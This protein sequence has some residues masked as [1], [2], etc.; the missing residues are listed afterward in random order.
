YVTSSERLV[1]ECD[2]RSDRCTITVTRFLGPM[3]DPTLGGTLAFAASSLENAQYT[4]PPRAHQRWPLLPPGGA[5]DLRTS[6][7]SYAFSRYPL[8]V[9]GNTRSEAYAINNFVE[10]HTL[11]HL[12]VV[13]DTRPDWA[14]LLGAPSVLGLVLV[15]KWVWGALRGS[16]R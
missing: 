11:Q 3:P 10:D 6:H 7:G 16:E 13:H 1:L 8:A 4:P 12:R 5:L 2:R 14:L 15:G 9:A